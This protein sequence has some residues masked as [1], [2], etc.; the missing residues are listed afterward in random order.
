MTAHGLR[1]VLH[2]GKPDAELNS[3]IAVLFLRTLRDN[4]ATLHAEN[5]NGDMLTGIIVD[6]GHSHLL[7]NYT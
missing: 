5:G 6:A 4:L 1:R 3:G 7:C 2:L